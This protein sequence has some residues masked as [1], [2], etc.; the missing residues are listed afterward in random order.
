MPGDGRSDRGRRPRA[1]DIPV[2]IRD[3]RP[4]TCEIQIG[5]F[6]ALQAA[7]LLDGPTTDVIS[8]LGVRA[9]PRLDPVEALSQH[10]LGA[11]ARDP[12]VVPPGGSGIPEKAP[13]PN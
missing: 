6:P 3:M 12:D 10:F 9:Y 11:C 2:D 5:A 13:A 8:D 4:T 1:T 7:S